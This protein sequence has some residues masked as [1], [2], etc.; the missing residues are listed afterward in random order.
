MKLIDLG[1][2]SIKISNDEETKNLVD[3]AKI[4]YG[5]HPYSQVCFFN[6]F[7]EIISSENIP[8][9]HLS[10]A[11]FF[12]GNL[13]VTDT[14]SLELCVDFPNIHKIIFYTSGVPW[15]QEKKHYKEWE[16]IF[17]RDNLTIIAQNQ[18]ISDIF[19]I[20]YKK[21]QCFSERLTYETIQKCI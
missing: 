14:K 17:Y 9:L 5:N 8:I 2:I 4:Y 20:C 15:L 10:Q 13:L 16:N 19:E 18:E 6:S 1:I 11:K 7:N 3:L 12:Y 21:P